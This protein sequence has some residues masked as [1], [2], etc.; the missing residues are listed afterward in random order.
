VA[1]P[2]AGGVTLAGVREHVR[3]A[4]LTEAVKAT[5]WLNVPTEVT[6]IV[7][8]PATPAFTVTEVGLAE[9]WKS[10]PELIVTV[11]TVELVMS[12][13]VPPVPLIVTV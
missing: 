11:M 5:A 3:P 9:I 10:D 12:L 4:G 7:D 8:V 2:P 6:V 13:F 1:V